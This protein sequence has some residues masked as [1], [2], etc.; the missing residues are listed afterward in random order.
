MN[1]PGLAYKNGSVFERLKFDIPGVVEVTKP[2]SSPKKPNSNKQAIKNNIIVSPGID[3][4]KPLWI[5]FAGA[6]AIT[7]LI[8][9]LDSDRRRHAIAVK[10]QKNI[11]EEDEEHDGDCDYDDDDNE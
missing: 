9:S 11:I 6:A 3:K 7:G 2:E 5:L 1:I 10:Y 4:T 8:W